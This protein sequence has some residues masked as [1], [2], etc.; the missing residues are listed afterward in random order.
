MIHTHIGSICDKV[1]SED[2]SGRYYYIYRNRPVLYT[3]D[4]QMYDDDGGPGLCIL[5]MCRDSRLD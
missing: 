4:R 5:L 2:R 1:N 3:I